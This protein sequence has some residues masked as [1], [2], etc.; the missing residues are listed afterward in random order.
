M[1][2]RGRVRGPW[3]N[4]TI[5]GFTVA[6][7]IE[8]GSFRYPD[9]PLPA[10]DIGLALTL[11]NPGGDIDSTAL[12]VSRFH[13][14]LGSDP[15]D[16]SLML[17]TPKSDP[18]VALRVAGRLDLA[19]LPEDREAGKSAAAWLVWS[20]PMRPCARA[21]PTSIASSTIA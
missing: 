21:C 11:N 2:V 7:S 15:I 9:L 5:P 10:R 3:G 13:A 17:R 19:N 8:N 18:D 16:G 12:N 6:A 4:G 1:S 20:W 14:V